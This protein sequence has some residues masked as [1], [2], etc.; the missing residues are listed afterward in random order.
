MFPRLSNP[1]RRIAC[2]YFGAAKKDKSQSDDKA[3]TIRN[4][5]LIF[6]TSG[7]DMH[8]YLFYPQITR[9]TGNIFDINKES[10]VIAFTFVPTDNY[11]NENNEKGRKSE[12]TDGKKKNNNKEDSSESTSMG[13]WN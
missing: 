13:N 6:K 11:T 2:C 10:T 4:Q 8:M 3:L 5:N 9:K 7:Y 1:S 12:K